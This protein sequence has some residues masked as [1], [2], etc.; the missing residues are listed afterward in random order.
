[1]GPAPAW[2]TYASLGLGSA[3]LLISIWNV[4][5]NRPRAGLA[6]LRVNLQEFE[7]D[8][9]ELTIGVF[10][11]GGGEMTVLEIYYVLPTRMAAFNVYVGEAHLSTGKL[12]DWVKGWDNLEWRF[13]PAMALLDNLAFHEQLDH[14]NLMWYDRLLDWLMSPWNSYRVFVRVGANRTLRSGRIETLR[15]VAARYHG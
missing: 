2:V 10:T 8:D 11:R 6:I 12:P 15:K 14:P 9:P 7:N 1:M 4:L 3:S 5:S 13:S